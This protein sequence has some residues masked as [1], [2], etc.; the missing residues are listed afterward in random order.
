MV[1]K[2]GRN[3]L[4]AVLGIVTGLVVGGC[5]CVEQ[6]TAAAPAPRA[7]PMVVRESGA[8]PVVIREGANTITRMAF[9]TGNAAT[10]VVMMEKKYPSEVQVG[11]PFEYLI[12]V[13]NLTDCPLD[14]VLVTDVIPST[15]KFVA[16]APQA[17]IG[18]DGTAKW[19][20]GKMAGKETKT[21]RVQVS[22]TGTGPHTYC[23]NVVYKENLCATV[24]AVEPKLRLTKTMPSDVLICDD[25]PV[26][27]VV[28]N[29]GTGAA[30]NVMVNDALPAGLVTK[31]GKTSLSFPAGSLGTGESKEF[32]FVATAQKAGKYDNQAVA[33]ADGNL[34]A[35]DAKSVTVR[36][37]ALAIA[38]KCPDMLFA[39]RP[40]T[41]EI[42]V[43]NT[44]DAAAKRVMVTDAVP[45]GTAFVSATDGGTMSNGIVMWSMDLEPKASKT[46]KMTA[47]MDT[48]G[49]MVNV[50]KASGVCAPEVRAECSTKV[51]GIPAVLL[52]MVDDP[53]PVEV[54]GQT[55]Y[56]ITATNQ[57]SM[58]DTNIRI[59]CTMED[60]EQFVTC[61]GA[62]QGTAQGLVVKF[63]PL[64]SLAPKARA[65]WTVTVKAVKEMNTR[66]KVTMN[67]DTLTRDVEETESTNLY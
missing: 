20:L 8:C 6:P 36:Q 4:M 46:V 55:T 58:T 59:T 45:V 66:F 50:A 37:P 47:R 67:T 54:G 43:T 7:K 9:P 22:A 3:V 57:G 42:T 62:T 40:A 23:G 1:K 24:V 32:S 19:A 10:S 30:T 44:G 31:D 16:S 15:L 33:K 21:I 41:Y 39:G 29:T 12:D 25:I 53:D 26:R 60:C 49:T 14:D 51:Q 64:P 34:E 48:I 2:L 63:A 13:T 61:G 27:L 11:S 65:T 28:T 56:T 18:Q 38:K 52:E 35:K 17:Q 5:A